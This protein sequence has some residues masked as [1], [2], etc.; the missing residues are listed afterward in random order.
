MTDVFRSLPARDHSRSVVDLTCCFQQPALNLRP[1]LRTIC[2]RTANPLYP[3]LLNWIAALGNLG[4]GDRLFHAFGWDGVTGSLI[5]LLLIV[6]VA[7]PL[8]LLF[9][10]AATYKD[11]SETSG[12]I[13]CLCLAL[14]VLC[15]LSIA[16]ILP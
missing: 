16:L 9:V 13:I 14:I 6:A 1:G 10:L 4:I 15:R 5:G 11:N 7:P 12:R 8:I 3:T 2:C